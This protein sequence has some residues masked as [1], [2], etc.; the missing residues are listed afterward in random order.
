MAFRLVEDGGK[1]GGPGEG[2]DVEQLPA[3]AETGERKTLPVRREVL[4]D[5]TMISH[6]SPTRLGEDL[7]R[8]GLSI[9]LTAEGGK[10]MEEASRRWP[11]RRVAVV[12]DGVVLVAAVIN[13]GVSEQL[14]IDLGEEAA[15][16]DLTGR[17]HAAAFALPEGPSPPAP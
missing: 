2:P 16:S 3:P 6:V 9:T 12:V 7:S 10:R 5:E 4:L 13:P 1:G 17:L 14:V 8:F 11:L 15:H